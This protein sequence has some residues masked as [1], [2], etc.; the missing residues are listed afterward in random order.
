MVS[1]VDKG[2]GIF[3]KNFED[4]YGADLGLGV[5]VRKMPQVGQVWGERRG[6]WVW[7]WEQEGVRGFEVFFFIG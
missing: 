4:F 6:E 7:G 2:K 5:G 3:V 1:R